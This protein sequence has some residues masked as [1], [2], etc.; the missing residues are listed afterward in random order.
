MTSAGVRP[1]SI[2]V[3]MT[4]CP[5]GC[6]RPYV[7]E[8]FFVGKAPGVYNLYLGGGFAGNRLGKM[9]REGVNE[10]QIMEILTPMLQDYGRNR[11][12]NEHFGDFVIRQVI[13]IIKRERERERER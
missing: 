11:Q 1:D 12:P 13:K 8:I 6:A 10:E 4:G 7:A 9:Y 5:N 3:R 2:T